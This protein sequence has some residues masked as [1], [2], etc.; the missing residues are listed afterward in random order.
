MKIILTVAILLFSVFGV[1]TTNNKENKVTFVNTTNKLVLVY[2]YS[3]KTVLSF[4][5][6]NNPTII[7]EVYTVSTK[8]FFNGIKFITPPSTFRIVNIPNEK[9]GVFYIAEHKIARL[10]RRKDVLCIDSGEF[11]RVRLTD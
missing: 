6:S 9:P 5:P 10:L 2:R 3:D 11:N 4:N 1:V 8:E 7:E